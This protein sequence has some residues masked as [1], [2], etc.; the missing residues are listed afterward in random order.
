[1]TR[2]AF[3]DLDGTIVE[4]SAGVEL[5]RILSELENCGKWREFWENQELFKNNRASYDDLIE[6]LSDNFAKGI[7]NTDA[8]VVDRAV[9][10]LRQRI[11][12]RANFCELHSWLVENR[13]EIFVL[14]S[15]PV[16]VF[17]AI[18]D[19]HFTETFGLVLDRNDKYTGRCILAMTTQIKKKIINQEVARG[20]SFS[21]GVS[22][23]VHDLEAY[24]KVDI[25]F[26]LSGS[27]SQDDRYFTVSNLLSVKRIVNNYLKLE[28]NEETMETE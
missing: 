5:A 19:F 8:R 9:Q 4:G 3:F 27:G 25:K 20:T 28:E 16:E 18:S 24:E 21:F 22:D 23:C 15:S 7:K 11:K 6:K 17:G 13:F 14:T 10:Q 26:L 1:M 12:I 2:K